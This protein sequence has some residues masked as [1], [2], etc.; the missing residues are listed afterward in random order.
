[1]VKR[2]S[3]QWLQTFFS[4]WKEIWVFSMVYQQHSVHQLSYHKSDFLYK[5]VKISVFGTKNY[6]KI[7]FISWCFDKM[8]KMAF[9]QK[10]D[11][12]SLSSVYLS[13]WRHG[14]LPW[15]FLG[16]INHGRSWIYHAGITK[17]TII[18]RIKPHPLRKHKSCFWSQ[19]LL[20][21]DRKGSL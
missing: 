8:R 17:E 14:W 19:N 21:K 4:Q 3:P 1:M 20:R 16:R 7:L 2:S 11:F 5:I 13:G 18:Q 6:Y 12:W 10:W 9:R 15:V